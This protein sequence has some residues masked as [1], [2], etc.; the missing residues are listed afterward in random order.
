MSKLVRMVRS[1][2][3]TTDDGT[4]HTLRAGNTVNDGTDLAKSVLAQGAG[5]I[6]GTQE[7]QEQKA[8]AK[9]K[10]KRKSKAKTK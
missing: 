2:R 9:K 10:R 3:V 4:V 5:I 7:P 6:V 8:S 1:C